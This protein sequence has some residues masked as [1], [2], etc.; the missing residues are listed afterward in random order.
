[1]TYHFDQIFDWL[2][3]LIKLV[4]HAGIM[5]E[6]DRMYCPTVVGNHGRIRKVHIE[7]IDISCH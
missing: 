6:V 5:F 2:Q 4:C 7:N 1:V 3:Q